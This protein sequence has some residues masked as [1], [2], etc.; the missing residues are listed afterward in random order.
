MKLGGA[1]LYTVCEVQAPANHWLPK[2]PCQTVN[3]GFNSPAFVGWFITPQGQV[4]NP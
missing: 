4:Y 1:G 2:P 3:V